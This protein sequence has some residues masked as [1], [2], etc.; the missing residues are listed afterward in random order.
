MTKCCN[1]KTEGLDFLFSLV[2]VRGM[3]TH[4]RT[5]TVSNKKRPTLWGG[6]FFNLFHIPNII[7]TEAIF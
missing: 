4:K 6:L 7:T 2:Y 1:N 3:K 5:T